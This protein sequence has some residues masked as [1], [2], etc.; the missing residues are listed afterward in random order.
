M[1]CQGLAALIQGQIYN[2]Y[3]YPDLSKTQ[4]FWGHSSPAIQ[5]HSPFHCRV[6]WSLVTLEFGHRRF[7]VHVSKPQCFIQTPRVVFGPGEVRH[8]WCFCAKKKPGDGFQ[9]FGVMLVIDFIPG[10]PLGTPS[11]T[12][13]LERVWSSSQRKPVFCLK[14]LRIQTLP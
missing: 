2:P 6:Q 14:S 9:R 12:I 8:G 10:N 4:L 11:F 5:V 13:I 1:S 3:K 7:I